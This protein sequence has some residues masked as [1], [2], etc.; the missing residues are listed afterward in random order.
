MGESFLSGVGFGE[1]CDQSV[2]Q[3]KHPHRGAALRVV[4][5]G[6]HQCLLT[7]ILDFVSPYLPNYLYLVLHTLLE[8]FI[9]PN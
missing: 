1:R 9:N 6:H 5:G 2:I 4:E 7:S 3:S 8:V